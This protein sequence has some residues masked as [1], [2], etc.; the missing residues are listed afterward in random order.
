ML[1]QRLPDLTVHINPEGRVQLSSGGRVMDGG[2]YTLALL[3]AFEHPATLDEAAARLASLATTD[4]QRAELLAQG[5]ELVRFGFLHPVDNALPAGDATAFNAPPIHIAMLEDRTRT[6][7]YLKA[8]AEGVQPGDI[9]LE[10]GTGSGVLACA[11][12]RAGAAHVYAVEGTSIA[13]TACEVIAAN[14]YAD[15]VTIIEGWSTRIELPARADI[16][17]AEIIGNEPLGEGLLEATYDAAQRLLKP[18]ARYLP[19]RIALYAQLYAL[20]DDLVEQ[21]VF[22]RSQIARWGR[23]YGFDFAPLLALNALHSDLIFPQ[24]LEDCEPRSEPILIESIDLSRITYTSFERTVLGSA[25][26]DG[27]INAIIVGFR[28]Q[29]DAQRWLSTLPGEAPDDNHWLVSL[30]TLPEPRPVRAGE[31]FTLHYSYDSAS[32]SHAFHID[33]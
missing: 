28:V 17:I 9:V 31:P 5:A 15:R 21:Q 14:G 19:A 20:P 8:I 4:A 23:W 1:L 18:D 3:E 12:A 32:R 7:A 2:L 33:S 26:A 11:A 22:T 13:A 25:N 10:I 30:R 16:L 27:F 24:E 6:G 29:L